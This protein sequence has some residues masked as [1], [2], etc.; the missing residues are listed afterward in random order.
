MLMPAAVLVV[1]ILGA[2]AVDSAV[3]YM[4][5][6]ELQDF[7]TSVADQ[8]ANASLD[9]AA[10]YGSGAVRLDEQNATQLADA[11]WQARNG[12]G[13]LTISD[14][15]VSFGAGDRT[16]TVTA[17]GTIHEVFGAVFRHDAVTLR[18]SSTATI[19]QDR[20]AF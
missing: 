10:F 4:G 15:R 13:G 9:K 18:A 2:I 14:V 12:S 5:H 3:A 20:V 1:L 7:T 17:T 6:R 19:V 16:L 8:A 11:A